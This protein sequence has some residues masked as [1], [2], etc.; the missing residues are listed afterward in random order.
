MKLNEFL[1]RHAVFTVE[2]LDRFLSAR[3]SGKPNT[4]K[5]L[6]TYYRNQGRIILVRRGLYATVPLGVDPVSNPVDPYLVA[7]KMTV[8]A[9][10]A[11]HTALEFHGRAYSVYTRL[12]YIS[13]SKSLP[14]K[15]QSHEFTCAPVPHPLRAK[16]K[17]MFGVTRHKRLG[18]EVRVTNLE[19]TLVDV[20]DRPDLTGSWEEIWRSLESVEFF[21]LDQVVE[22][23]LL[24]ENATTTAKVGFFLEQHK[25]T[26]MVDDA[27]LNPLRKL[28]PRQP[29]YLI[30]GKRKGCQWVKEWNLM[31]PVEILNKSWG[32]VL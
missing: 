13:A 26:L 1:S 14:L 20:L 25:E 2:E 27:H 22:Y 11:Y 19:R 31:I 4:R 12:H 23:A 16:G 10:L 9:V 5:S 21:D 8:D 6:L 15:F 28:R 24:L 29:H 7:A 30:R 3:G 32:V 18:V 17:E